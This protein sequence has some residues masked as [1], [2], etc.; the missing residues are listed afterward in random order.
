MLKKAL[1]CAT[2]AVAATG[3]AAALAPT[4]QASDVHGGNYSQNVN[5]LPHLCLDVKRVSPATLAPIDALTETSGQQC[6][7]KSS[8]VDGHK[9]ALSD[10]ADI[11]AYQN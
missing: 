11:G 8:V 6:N 2:L 7:E 4:A 10:L 3:S 5:V 1:A 9:S